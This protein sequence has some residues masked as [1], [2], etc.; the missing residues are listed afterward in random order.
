MIAA[1]GNAK[2]FWYLTRGTGVVALLLLTASVALGVLTTSRWRTPR[3]P[4]FAVSAVHRNLTLL[5]VV[6]I[7]VHV[8]TTV[9]DGYAPIRL[10]DALVPFV[11]RYRPVWLGLGAVAFDL[12]LA[13]VIT[14][15]L[16]ARFGYRLWRKVH[17]LAYASWPLALVHAF[18]SGS[19]ARVGFM[20][21]AG[22]GSLAVVALAALTRVAVTP[23]RRTPVQAA[24]AL[25]ALLAPLAIVAWYQGGPAKHG[26]AKRAG[27]PPTLLASSRTTTRRVAAAR[28]IQT[29]FSA[30]LAGTI[31]ETTNPNGLVDVVIAGRLN[32]GRVGAVRIDLRGEPQQDGV[33]MT[34]SGVSYVPAGTST[35]FKGSVAR[36]D[37]QD[38]VALV[39][40][41]GTQLQL[42]F[43]L[44]IDAAAGTVSGSVAGS[45]A[46]SE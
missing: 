44:N 27:T 14:S 42:S 30:Q 8:V 12:I 32:D 41:G 39:S 38:V 21:A 33:S 9:L 36:L 4:R 18:G 34:A 1:A 45:P 3:W 13:L 29:S 20:V 43:S 23:G 26:W 28:P 7:V 25:V 6:F 19:D 16:R 5:A 2:T 22:F 11:S 24:A 15:L 17:W 10:V 37:G 31:V 40:A 46:E 35:V